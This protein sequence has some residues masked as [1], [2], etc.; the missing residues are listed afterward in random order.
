[1]STLIHQGT[2][3]ATKSMSAQ[4]VMSN[5]HFLQESLLYPI[6][7]Y[8]SILANTFLTGYLIERFASGINITVTPHEGLAREYYFLRPVTDCQSRPTLPLER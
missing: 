6:Y 5:G 1:M 7:S 8:A 3:K 4:V 2:Q